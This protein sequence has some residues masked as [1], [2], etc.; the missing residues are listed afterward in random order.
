M[1]A[2][3]VRTGVIDPVTLDQLRGLFFGELTRGR[4]EVV[5][6]ARR[7]LAA[8]EALVRTHSVGQGLRTLD[9]IQLSVALDLKRRGAASDLVASDR[10]LCT[11]A[12]LEGLSV[13]NPTEPA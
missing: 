1:F 3:K 8:A 7:H 9:A 6:L 10:N 13:I 11:V 4:F 12:S 5:L 2:T